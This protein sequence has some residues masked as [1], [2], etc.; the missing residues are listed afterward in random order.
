MRLIDGARTQ[1]V[2]NDYY[3]P[4]IPSYFRRGRNSKMKNTFI[5]NN[6][7]RK[8][9]RRYLRHN[10]TNAEKV[11]WSRLQKSQL[12]VKFRRQQSIGPYIVDFFCPSKRIVIE[13][14]GKVHN[15]SKD[16]DQYRTSYLNALDIEVIRFKNEEV[17]SSIDSVLEELI[18]FLV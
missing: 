17:L 2:R 15:K 1:G 13:I 6:T 5:Y 12:G 14:D 3:L 11:M 7:K 10:T 9:P 4:S 8:V 16:Y 18:P